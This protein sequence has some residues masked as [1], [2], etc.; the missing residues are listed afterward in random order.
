MH[1]IDAVFSHGDNASRAEVRR[2]FGIPASVSDVSLLFEIA[3]SFVL[4]AQSESAADHLLRRFCADH[5]V[6]NI[7]V[8][9]QAFAKA[10]AAFGFNASTFDP[11]TPVEGLRDPV[12]LQERVK[13]CTTCIVIGQVHVHNPEARFRS[14]L[15]NYSFYNDTCTALFGFRLMVGEKYNMLCGGLNICG[16]S[17][18]FTYSAQDLLVQLMTISADVT[19]DI[20]ADPIDG[21]SASS[22]LAPGAG[23][24][25]QSLKDVRRRETG[26]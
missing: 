21:W 9:A 11:R 14:R 26:S 4:M 16:S 19:S 1:E 2:L 20:C 6:P 25:L 23:E 5:S 8:V 7:T 18:L 13:W 22:D 12:L 3:E 15:V 24:R 10:L 17:T